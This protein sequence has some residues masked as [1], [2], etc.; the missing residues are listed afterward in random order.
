MP[1]KKKGGKGKG[2]SGNIIDGVD[3]TQMTREQLEVFCHR[4]KEEN[5]REREERNFFQLE[6][7][8]LRTFWEITKNELEEAKAKLRNK[9]RQ[10]EEA[11]EKN[12]EE[13]KFYKQKVKHLQYEHQNNLTECKAEALVSLKMSQDDHTEQERELLRDKRDLKAQIREQEVAHQDQI[14]SL[15]LQHSEE[16]SN[17]RNQFELKEKELENKYEK[18]FADLKQELNIKHTME[19]SELEERKNNQITDLT[20]HHEKVFNEMKNYYNDITLNNLALISSLK[21]Q[22]EVLRKQNERMSKQVADITAENKRLTEPLKQAQIDVAE[23]KRQLEHYEKDKLSLANTKAKL[24]TTKQELD[25]LRWAN[26]ALQLRFE[27]LE[28]EKDEL[29]RRFIDAILDVQQKT[30]QKNMLLQRRVQTLTNVAEYRDVIIGELRALT[31][32]DI[33]AKNLKLEKV[34]ARKN[35]VIHDLQYELARVCKAHDDLL[36]TYEDKLQ[37]YGIPKEELG[38]VPL[39]ILQDGQGG[40]PK[41]PAGLVTKNR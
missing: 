38:F 10:I 19:M 8:K 20:K 25:D 16:I 22:M 17:I 7:D 41:G 34:L 40:L 23:Y 12:D 4:I 24:S 26:D 18:K 33:T 13:L 29:S 14:K 6:R 30:G 15:K 9:D 35:T 11:A 3:T 1:P 21:D 31:S 5:E 36:D 28:A 37:Q 32:E 39:R 2:G 27:K